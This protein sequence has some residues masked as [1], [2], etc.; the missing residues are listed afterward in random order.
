M[1]I[2]PFTGF[3]A[4]EK[5]RLSPIAGT[6]DGRVLRGTTHIRALCAHL[7]ATSKVA[8]CLKLLR[9]SPVRAYLACAFRAEA[10][11]CSFTGSPCRTCTFSRLSAKGRS[12]ATAAL[13][14]LS[15]RTFIAPVKLL[16]IIP[17]PLH[18]VKQ[19]PR[20][21]QRN[22]EEELRGRRLLCREAPP[23]DPLPK[24][25]GGRNAGGRGRF[26]KRSASPPR[27]P[28]PE[29]WMGIDL[30]VSSNLR[31]YAR[32]ARV[33]CKLVE[34]TAADRAAADVRGVPAGTERDTL[35]QPSADSSLCEGS[36]FGE[37]PR[38]ASPERGGARPWRAEGF[39]P[40]TAKVAA[41]LSA[42]VTITHP[43]GDTPHSQAEPTK[44][45]RARQ[46]PTALR[47][48]GGLGERRFSQRSGL[49]PRI[50]HL[51]AVNLPSSVSMIFRRSSWAAVVAS[52]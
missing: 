24:R 7:P 6:K 4:I 36:L 25:R 52:R 16:C 12:P 48:R 13:H 18:P 47:E 49:S 37:P 9:A 11:S 1:I 8:D 26:S 15:R 23:P 45:N 34:S 46:T 43:I 31:A 21:V 20:E 29:E 44:Q 19:K 3:A 5:D 32:W 27:P 2:T 38:K 40:H 33:P 14:G 50:S 30:Y 22:T 28:S 17:R 41:A 39:V 42:A 35:S 51:Y 10:P